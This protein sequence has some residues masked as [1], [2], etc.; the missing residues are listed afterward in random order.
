MVRARTDS[1]MRAYIDGYNNC[2]KS[3]IE[4]L[5]NNPSDKAIERMKMLLIATNS[6]LEREDDN[7][8]N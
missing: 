8:R 6:V 7:G 1:E 2:Y 4:L 5:N 3:F